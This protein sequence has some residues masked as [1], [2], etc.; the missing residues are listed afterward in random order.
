MEKLLGE[1]TG[2]LKSLRFTIGKSEEVVA[3][4]NLEAYTSSLQPLEVKLQA[5]CAQ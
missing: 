5:S 3:W 1:L 2:K 4:S